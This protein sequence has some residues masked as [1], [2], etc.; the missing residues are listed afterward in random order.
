MTDFGTG[1]F[2]KTFDKTGNH[3][4]IS[5]HK[6]KNIEYQEYRM[7]ISNTEYVTT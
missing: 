4:H 2:K 5:E 1:G 7:S 6:S 3:M